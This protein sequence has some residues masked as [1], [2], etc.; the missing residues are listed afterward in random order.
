MTTLAHPDTWHPGAPADAPT[1]SW[2]G[3]DPDRAP[4]RSPD[5]SPDRGSGTPAG[6]RGVRAWWGA[7]GIRQKVL[8]P[9][10]L[11]ALVAVVVG[12]A[13][14]RS[15]GGA[16]AETQDVYDVNV[17]GQEALMVAV[18]ARLEVA[19]AVRDVLIAAPGTATDEAVAE[20]DQRFADLRDA[21][22][23]YAAT[24]LDASQED[25]ATGGPDPSRGIFPT[26]QIVTDQGANEASEDEIR[27]AY[28]AVVG[29]R[30][31]R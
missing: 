15:L 11:A 4:D 25:A 17:V 13:G 12:V 1:T 24:P 21:I 29:E 10:L 30:D 16:A 26:M 22:S 23:G 7:R 9:A 2:G 14:I 5:R 27:V 8:V 18:E 19:L 28:E 3:A 20:L 31:G 6:P